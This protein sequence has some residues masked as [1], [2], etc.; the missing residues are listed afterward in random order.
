M[1]AGNL[2]L[3]ILQILSPVFLAALTWAVGRLARLIRVKIHNEDLR[4][5][6]LR[7]DDAVLT[8]V[9]ALQQT[10]VGPLNADHDDGKLIDVQQQLKPTALASV[11]SILGP[12]GRAAVDRMRGASAIDHNDFLTSRIQAAAHDLNLRRADAV[13][14][15]ADAVSLRADTPA[16]ALRPRAAYFFSFASS[17]AIRFFCVGSATIACAFSYA[18]IAPALSPFCASASP[19]LSCAFH[20]CG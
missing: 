8:A 16:P 7:I 11:K 1:A 20:D 14:L 6:L 2:G 17:C 9:K 3:E 13:P 12:T 19:R 4:G 5:I 18:A 10:Q 15:R